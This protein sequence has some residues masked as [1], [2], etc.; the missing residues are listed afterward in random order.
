MG[1]L[2]SQGLDGR[3]RSVVGGV[4]RRARDSLFRTGVDD[5]RGV[6]LVGP[7]GGTAS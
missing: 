4:A 3:F 2:F 7:G 1:Q 6:L 5:D